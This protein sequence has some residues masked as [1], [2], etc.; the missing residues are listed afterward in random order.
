MCVSVWF[1]NKQTLFTARDCLGIGQDVVIDDIFLFP[2][3]DEGTDC[4][5]ERLT[6]RQMQQD[7]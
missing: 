6:Q 4:C 1:P 2:V 3:V 7:W 5:G